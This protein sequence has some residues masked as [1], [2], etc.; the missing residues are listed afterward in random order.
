MKKSMTVLAAIFL[1]AVMSSDLFALGDGP[2]KGQGT[3]PGFGPCYEGNVPGMRG[4]NLTPEQTKKINE[5][6][7]AQWKSIA[8]L[9][10]KMFAKRDELRLLWLQ[11]NPD[12]EKINAA[13][14]EMR[15]LRDKMQDQMTSA[16]LDMLN[17]L[18]PE[19]RVKFQAAGTRGHG[20]GPYAGEQCG[21]R[22]GM[23]RSGWYDGHGRGMMGN[24]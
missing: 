16:R 10:E 22:R 7:E 9:R 1:V 5:L 21:G 18:T 24:Y 19:Q 3:G 14:A 6:R 2:G 11:A 15:T 20:P 12:R 4:L 17:L 8:P 13:Q 23:M